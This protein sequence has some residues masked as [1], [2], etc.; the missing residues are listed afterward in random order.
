[1]I[2]KP[3]EGDGGLE[4]QVTRLTSGLEVAHRRI[5]ELLEENEALRVEARTL[6]EQIAILQ[7]NQRRAG[8][9]VVAIVLL[10]LTAIS[11]GTMRRR[12]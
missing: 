8:C 11:V 2:K 9:T 1:M 3:D 5:E 12:R 10:A 6:R 4:L 7:N